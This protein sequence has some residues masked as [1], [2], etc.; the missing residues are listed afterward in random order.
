MRSSSIIAAVAAVSLIAPAASAQELGQEVEKLGAAYAAAF[1]KQDAAG[2]A[3]LFTTD[4]VLVSPSGVKSGP[5]AIEQNY[6][7]LF[8]AGINHIEATVDQVSALG[9]DAVLMIGEYHATGEG[10]Y[11]AIKIDGHWTEVGVRE[12]GVLKIRLRAVVRDP[13]APK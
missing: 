2:I 9:A 10:Q 12:G 7:T 4:G 5:A 3:T 8:K 1:N 11:G 13:P 6:H